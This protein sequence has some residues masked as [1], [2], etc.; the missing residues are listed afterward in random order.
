MVSGESGKVW[1]GL[2]EPGG[3]WWDLV[4]LVDLRFFSPMHT[5]DT[6]ITQLLASPRSNPRDAPKT[7]TQPTPLGRCAENANRAIAVIMWK[8]VCR[9]T[10]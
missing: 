4:V 10:K 5:D 8:E 3:V 1:W 7:R 6:D 2:V 9:D